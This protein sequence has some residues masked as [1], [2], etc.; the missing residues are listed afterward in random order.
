MASDYLGAFDKLLN[1][2]GR[3]ATTLPRIKELGEAFKD[4]PALLPK[5]AA[6]YADILDFHHSAYKFVTRKCR[7]VL[8]GSL[9]FSAYPWLVHQAG[10]YF[11]QQHGQPSTSDSAPFLLAWRITAIRSTMKLSPLT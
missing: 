5:L 2:Y 1:A 4:S 7:F 6:Y 8:Q 10:A 11:S 3:I 9:T